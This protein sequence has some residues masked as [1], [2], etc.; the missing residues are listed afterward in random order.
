MDI[1]KYEV[2]SDKLRWH[3]NPSMFDF[4]CTKDLA[5]LREFLGQDKA[6]HAIDFGLVRCGVS[7]ER[8]KQI[9]VTAQG[10]L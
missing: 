3:C 5:P 9:H 1:A 8:A 4:E 7:S 6:I 10:V 2:P